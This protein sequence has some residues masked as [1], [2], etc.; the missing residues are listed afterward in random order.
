MAQLRQLILL[1]LVARL[2]PRV[3]AVSVP[4]RSTSGSS[5]AL[6][7]ILVRSLPGHHRMLS[8][9]EAGEGEGHHNGTSTSPH[10]TPTAPEVAPSNREQHGGTASPEHWAPS[11]VKAEVGTSDWHQRR[12]PSNAPGS[13]GSDLTRATSAGESYV[14]KGTR[15]SHLRAKDASGATMCS[16]SSVAPSLRRIEV[17]SP[18]NFNVAKE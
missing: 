12:A 8:V 17:L 2:A 1:L 6:P 11:T 13:T 3:R 4:R 9:S 15:V 14:M 18:F 16:M 10:E 7:I 5:N